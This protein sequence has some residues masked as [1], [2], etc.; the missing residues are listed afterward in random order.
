M[1]NHSSTGEGV[2]AAEPSARSLSRTLDRPRSSTELGKLGL[3]PDKPSART[4]LHHLITGEHLSRVRHRAPPLE[5][6]KPCERGRLERTGAPGA[7]RNGRPCA[8][9]VL[10][11]TL[12]LVTCSVA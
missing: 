8:W 7:G 3:C 10:S 6:A 2:Q 1:V 5:L 4:H 12:L 9:V 11:L